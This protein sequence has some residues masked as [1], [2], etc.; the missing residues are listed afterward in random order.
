MAMKIETQNNNMGACCFY[1]AQGCILTAIHRFAYRELPE[2][3]Q[4]IWHKPIG[5]C[6]VPGTT[7]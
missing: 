5:E 4:L 1:H 2:E 7:I 3:T 6:N